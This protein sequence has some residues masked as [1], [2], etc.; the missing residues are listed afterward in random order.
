MRTLRLIVVGLVVIGCTSAI[1]AIIWEFIGTEDNP[2]T[3]MLFY[4]LCIAALGGAG[5]VLIALR[6]SR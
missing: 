4:S 6:D 5:M 3:T 1:G 2:A